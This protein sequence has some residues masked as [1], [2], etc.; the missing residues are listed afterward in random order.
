MI[1]MWHFEFNQDDF[2]SLVFS[3]E[4]NGNNNDT[5]LITR[6]GGRCQ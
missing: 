6:I 4:K 1:Q 2:D 3:N 5:L